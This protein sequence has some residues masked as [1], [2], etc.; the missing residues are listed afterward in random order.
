[1]HAAV[2][3]E[4]YLDYRIA[5]TTGSLG[6]WPIITMRM[7]DEFGAVAGDEVSREAGNTAVSLTPL[8]TTSPHG[9]KEDNTLQRIPDY[10]NPTAETYLLFDEGQ[11]TYWDV[12]FWNV[13]LKGYASFDNY[14]VILF[15]SYGSSGMQPLNYRIGA[16]L[17][18]NPVEARVSLV[19]NSEANGHLRFGAMGLLFSRTEL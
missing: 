8:Y 14:R 6:L 10:P 15:C 12:S 13:F 18:L 4:N 17:H 1:M 7:V 5:C 3:S 11:D 9:L 19:P 16:P 2:L